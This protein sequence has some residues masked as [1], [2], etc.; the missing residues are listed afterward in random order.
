MDVMPHHK[1]HY[2]I[3]F[4]RFNEIKNDKEFTNMVKVNREM[5]YGSYATSQNTLEEFKKRFIEI[6]NNIEFNNLA[7]VN[8]QIYY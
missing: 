5:Y 7:G 3:L 1:F 4:L 2:L 6:I 8:P